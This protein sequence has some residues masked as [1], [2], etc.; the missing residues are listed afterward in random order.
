MAVS[1]ALVFLSLNYFFLLKHCSTYKK[2]FYINLFACLQIQYNA[3]DILSFHVII[4]VKH[5]NAV[6]NS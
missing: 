5:N 2:I 1:E 3:H 6:S 4:Q